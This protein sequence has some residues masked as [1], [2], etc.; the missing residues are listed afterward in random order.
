MKSARSDFVKDRGGSGRDR[1]T[2]IAGN[3]KRFADFRPRCRM[4]FYSTT[5]TSGEKISG[6]LAKESYRGAPQLW[7]LEIYKRPP[8]PGL[9]FGVALLQHNVRFWG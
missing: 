5:K 7:T 6:H 2:S 4:T 1:G 9:I 8:G 3:A